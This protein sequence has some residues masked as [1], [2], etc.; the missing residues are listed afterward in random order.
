M[1][2]FKSDQFDEQAKV[3]RTECTPTI[4]LAQVFYGWGNPFSWIRALATPAGTYQTNPEF[5]FFYG[6]PSDRH[7]VIESVVSFG[8]R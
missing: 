1:H 4:L 7:W 5:E 8:G 6:V 3:D 2:F